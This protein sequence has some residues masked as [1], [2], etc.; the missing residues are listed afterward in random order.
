M[1][2]VIRHRLS[3]RGPVW[4]GRMLDVFDSPLLAAPVAWLFWTRMF[5]V[6]A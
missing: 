1:D 2:F 3:F 5:H 4:A 6:V